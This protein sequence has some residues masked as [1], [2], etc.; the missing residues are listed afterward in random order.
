MAALAGY[1]I[2]ALAAA[3]IILLLVNVSLSRALR[4]AEKYAPAPKKSGITYHFE[5]MDPQYVSAPRLTVAIKYRA[6]LD[7]IKRLREYYERESGPP[8]DL[9]TPPP[10]FEAP[11]SN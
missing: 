8:G 6:H 5:G 9:D 4:Q 7:E 11:R 1:A 10:T 2:V 3:C